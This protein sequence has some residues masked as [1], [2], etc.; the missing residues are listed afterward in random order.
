[1]EDDATLMERWIGG[2]DEAGQRLCARHHAEVYRFFEFKIAN[3]ADD[4]AQQTFLACVTSRARF[5]GASSFRTYLLG[6]AKN[7]LY[8][9]LRQKA[10][11]PEVDLEVS[12]IEDLVTSPSERLGRAHDLARLRAALRQLPVAQQV[13][14]E[15]HY[16][17]D[18]D[19]GMLAEVF[20][21]SPGAIRVRLLRARRALRARLE[22][23]GDVPVASDPLSSSLRDPEREPDGADA[24]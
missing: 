18:L 17:H 13:L 21:T 20:E 15:L 1:V 8:G 10:R 7:V 22:A 14:L 11:H 3:E 19:M 9:R 23:A 2:D 24:G 12:S 4:L 16:W 5:R 6:I